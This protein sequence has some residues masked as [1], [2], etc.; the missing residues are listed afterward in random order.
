LAFL[1]TACRKQTSVSAS[2]Y[3]RNDRQRYFGA[4][5]FLVLAYT[6]T[7]LAAGRLPPSYAA[8]AV[9]LVPLIGLAAAWWA[10]A[11]TRKID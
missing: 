6:V 2:A 4:I 10:F 9:F 8:G 1:A 5:V 11:P 3:S 7:M